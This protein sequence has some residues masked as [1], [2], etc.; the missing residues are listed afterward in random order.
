MLFNIPETILRLA[1]KFWMVVFKGLNYCD[2]LVFANISRHSTHLVYSWSSRTAYKSLHQISFLINQICG[3]Q[4]FSQMRLGNN[5]LFVCFFTSFMASKDFVL[6][7]EMS[8][9]FHFQLVIYASIIS[10]LSSPI[11]IVFA[12]IYW[13]CLS[14]LVSLTLD[15]TFCESI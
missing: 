10:I 15:N 14:I 11:Y 1:F 13:S 8:G 3:H 7:L 9:C 12:R 2:D 4:L 6:A 5:H